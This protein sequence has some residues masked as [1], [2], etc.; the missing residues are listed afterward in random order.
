MIYRTDLNI[1]IRTLTELRH[2]LE[3]TLVLAQHTV[4]HDTC[5][6]LDA[7]LDNIEALEKEMHSLDAVLD[8]LSDLPSDEEQMRLQ[9]EYDETCEDIPF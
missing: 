4:N 7:T 2:R 6:D 9:A 5:W 3:R 1:T 8:G